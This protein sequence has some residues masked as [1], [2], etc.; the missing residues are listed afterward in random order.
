MV[1]DEERERKIFDVIRLHHEKVKE[2]YCVVMTVLCGSQNYGLDTADSD[3]DT[4]TFVLPTMADLA[5]LNEPVSTLD[6][7]K[8]GHINIKDIRLALN[9]LKKTSPNSVEWF[10]TRYRIIEPVYRGLIETYITPETLRCNTS[11]M[12][13][14]IRGMAHQLTMRNMSPGK[15]YSHLIR[16]ECMVDNYYDLSSDL[17]SLTDGSRYIAQKVKRL[18]YYPFYDGKC[19]EQ[20]QFIKDKIASYADIDMSYTESIGNDHVNKFQMELIKRHLMKIGEN[21]DDM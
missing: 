1:P 8:Y 15:R 10:A 6:E 14:A 3:Y 4:Y 11:N 13:H 5:L 9:L 20:E 21:K 16:L 19:F 12:M 17:L 7:D 2:N 18:Q